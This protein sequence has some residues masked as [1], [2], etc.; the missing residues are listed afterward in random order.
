MPARSIVLLDKEDEKAAK[1]FY[2]LQ[3]LIQTLP[4]PK[5]I[6]LASALAAHHKAFFWTNN[7]DMFLTFVF[8][9]LYCS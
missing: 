4:P 8:F 3:K 2:N 7:C 6:A 9:F 5:S 1:G